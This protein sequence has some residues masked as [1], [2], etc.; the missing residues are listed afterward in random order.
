[1]R[2]SFKRTHLSCLFVRLI[3]HLYFENFKITTEVAL[4]LLT[5]ATI[6]LIVPFKYILAFLLMDLFT[7]EFEF[8]RE[9]VKK[10]IS[11]LKERWDTVPAAP[12]V[13]LPFESDESR[14]AIQTRETTEQDIKKKLEKWQE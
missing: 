3:S 6:L 1:M 12:V 9:M 13:V 2:W 4:L 10:F 5:S 7:R 14:T 8:R 11:F